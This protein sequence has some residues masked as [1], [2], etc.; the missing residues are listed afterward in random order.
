MYVFIFYHIHIKENE[1][2]SLD[3]NSNA[4][5]AIAS[6]IHYTMRTTVNATKNTVQNLSI[7]I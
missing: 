5:S 1:L 4:F 3:S 2:T 6:T 7:H